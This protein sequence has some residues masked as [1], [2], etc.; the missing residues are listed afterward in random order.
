LNPEAA[1]VWFE[2]AMCHM[3][4]RQWDNARSSLEK[5]VNLDSHNRQYVT[6]LGFCLA[7]MGRY[8]E[9][10]D[11]F[12]QVVSKSEALYK[13]ARMAHHLKDDDV[14]VTLLHEALQEKP[15]YGPARCMLDQLQGHAPADPD[16]ATQVSTANQEGELCPGKEAK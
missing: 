10:L 8:Q 7:R 12:T 15:D 16:H 13:V 11:L 14:S 4:Q 1:T 2:I 3:R 9:S 6:T 5:A